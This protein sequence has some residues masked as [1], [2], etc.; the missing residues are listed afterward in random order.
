VPLNSHRQRLI[1]RLLPLVLLVAQ[2]GAVTHAYSHLAPDLRTT[3][4]LTQVCATCISQLPLLSMAGSLQSLL[5]PDHCTGEPVL[6]ANS[7]QAVFHL[8]RPTSRSRAPPY[9]L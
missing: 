7:T 2:L 3:P 9:V 1:A 5:P 6:A 4:G 8:F